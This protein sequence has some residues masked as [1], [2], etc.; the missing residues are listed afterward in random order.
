VCDCS[1]SGR[2]LFILV[3]CLWGWLWTSLRP[4]LGHWSGIDK[5]SAN[6]KNKNDRDPSTNSGCGIVEGTGSLGNSSS[7]STIFGAGAG[8]SSLGGELCA[9]DSVGIS[10]SGS[11][12]HDTRVRFVNCVKKRQTGY[13]AR[14][15]FDEITPTKSISSKGN[16][17]LLN[18]VRY[19]A[20]TTCA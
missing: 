8:R 2:G 6:V 13:V 20:C 4:R 19:V 16:A 12:L 1:E 15:S 14:V 5:V 9:G 7:R 17:K 3:G 18:Y 10:N 11:Y